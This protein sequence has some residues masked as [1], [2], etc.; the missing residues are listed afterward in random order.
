MKIFTLTV[1]L[2]LFIG[3]ANA[4]TKPEKMITQFFEDYQAGNPGTAL[5]NLYAN[6]PWAEEIGDEVTNLKTQ[7][8]GLQNLVGSYNG[9]VLLAKKDLSGIFAI[10]SYMVKFDRQPVRFVFEFYK[11]KDKWTLYSFSYDVKIDDELEKS[12]ELDKVDLGK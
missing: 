6:M 9:H 1:L 11:P 5:D 10:F 12:L 7:F 2:T 8:V 4:Q 3:M